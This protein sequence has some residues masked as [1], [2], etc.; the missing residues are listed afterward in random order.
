MKTQVPGIY[1]WKFLYG[2]SFVVILPLL[3]VRWAAL[4][5][6]FVRLPP[7]AAP[8][9]GLILMIVGGY[10]WLAGVATLIYYGRGLPM[11]AFP[12]VEFVS[13]GIFHVFPHPIY[14]GF[15]A[16]CIG[17]AIY[18]GSS[19][20][21]WL[22]TPIVILSCVAL[23][24]GF[25]KDELSKRFGEYLPK[26]LLGLPSR[27]LRAPLPREIYSVYLLVFFPWLVLYELVS[28][29]GVPSDA[30]SSYLPFE[31]NIPV[32]DWTEIFYGATYIFVMIG[33]IICRSATQLREFAINGLIATFVIILTFLT[34]PLIAAP[35]LFMPGSFLGAIL[36]REQNY[37]TSAAAFPSFHVVWAFLAAKLYAGS[38]PRLKY[39]W[40][41]VAILVSLSCITTGMHSIIDVLGGI[42]VVIGVFK[43]REIWNWVRSFS[44]RFANSWKEWQFG[45]VRIINHG[46]YT[47]LGSFI[48]LLIVGNLLGADHVGFTLIIFSSSLI[49]AGLW[50]QFIEGSPRL[51]RPYGYY[52]GVVGVIVGVFLAGLF[53]GNTWLLFGACSVAGPWIQATGRLRCLVQGC[54][55]GRQT[56]A[57]IGIRFTHPRSRV[58]KIAGFTG[59]PLHPTQVYSIL[60]NIFC[61]IILARLWSVHTSLP[62]ISGMYLILNGLGRFVEESYRGEP[63][64]P[65][66]GR[67]RL[68]QW[69]S[70]LSVVSGIIVTTLVTQTPIPDP[71]MNWSSLIA[72]IGFGLFIWFAQGVDFP[73]SNRRFAR[74]T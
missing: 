8:I 34:I 18:I 23:V 67:M 52:G 21:L 32:F 60:W 61:G 59:V 42:L 22:V 63:Q 25:E 64:T 56:T 29:I 51:L 15:C 24:Q 74:L 50:G 72:G 28:Y 58:N 2:F 49:F 20:G 11:N 55:H 40:W 69:M 57:G 35:K 14:T 26:P 13:K 43:I 7:I 65:V 38:F 27:E 31:K 10:I 30:L 3:L 73:N 62:L 17:Y 9:P 44:E 53:D 1:F 41:F 4:T 39:F 37:D 19:S 45:N 54:C 68:Y 48:G 70:L 47:G 33:P 36:I 46:L 71:D 5:E 66:F 16:I 12:P 6:Q